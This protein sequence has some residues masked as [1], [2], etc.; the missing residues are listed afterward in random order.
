MQVPKPAQFL[1]PY[2]IPL[3]IDGERSEVE[4][5]LNAGHVTVVR[6]ALEGECQYQRRSD[7]ECCGSTSRAGRALDGISS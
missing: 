2:S 1:S 4:T 5:L 6:L 7:S 3:P